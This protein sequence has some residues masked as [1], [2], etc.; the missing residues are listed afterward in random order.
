MAH[1]SRFG[2]I[3]FVEKIILCTIVL[4]SIILWQTM[5]E[6]ISSIFFQAKTCIDFGTLS[7]LLNFKFRVH[8]HFLL[9][10]INRQQESEK[11]EMK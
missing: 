3:S 2:A 11:N 7:N 6:D 5:G 8:T 1:K 4:K 9:K 10:C